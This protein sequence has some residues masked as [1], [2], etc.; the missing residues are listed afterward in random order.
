ME[1]SL[2]SGLTQDTFKDRT[3]LAL[4][5][6]QMTLGN[7]CAQHFEPEAPAN[8]FGSKPYYK[9]VKSNVIHSTSISSGIDLVGLI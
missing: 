4:E 8:K 5:Q 6:R 2:G 3:E 9:P 7:F 1:R